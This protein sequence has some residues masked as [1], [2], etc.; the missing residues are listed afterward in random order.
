LKK[1]LYLILIIFISNNIIKAQDSI[2]QKQ[3]LRDNY[4]QDVSEKLN[5]SLY[6]LNNKSDFSLSGNNAL[7]LN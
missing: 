4:V 6:F 5:V 1:I 2:G 3:L 7:K